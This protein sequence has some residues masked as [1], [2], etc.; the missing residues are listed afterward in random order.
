MNHIDWLAPA[1]AAALP[2][3]EAAADEADSPAAR[4]ARARLVAKV[5]ASGAV[6]DRRVLAALGDV[7][8]HWF[9]DAP[10]SEAYQDRPLPIGHQQT[11]SQPLIV[12]MMT[13]A[14]VLEGGE[15]VLEIGTGS[16]YQAAVLARMGAPRPRRPRSP[17]R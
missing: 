6:T 16:G 14:L 3:A 12:G 4:E 9:V 15:R 2:A 1:V 5:A 8:R 11:I 13:E 7:P 10:L 17:P